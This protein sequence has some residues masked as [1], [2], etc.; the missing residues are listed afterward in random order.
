MTTMDPAWTRLAASFEGELLFDELSRAVYATDASLY[1]EWPLAVAYPKNASDIQLLVR[2]AAQNKL[3]LIPRAGGTSLAGQCV[4]NGIVVDV[5]R[6][7]NQILEFDPEEKWVRVQPGVVRDELNRFLKPHGLFFGP[8]TS[9]TNRCTIGGMAGNNSCG[10]TSIR[11][12][13]TRDHALEIEAVLS[14]GSMARFGEG[15]PLDNPFAQSL[16]RQMQEILLAEP[17]LRDHFP[18]ASIHRRNT[19]YAFDVFLDKPST[20]CPLLCGSEGTLCFFTEIKIHLEPL[21]PP[22]EVLV[23]AHFASVDEALRAV[24]LAMQHPLYACEMMDKTILDCTKE[25]REQRKNRF[26]LEGD[27][28]AVLILE[29]RGNSP[30]EAGELADRL[31]ESLRAES[32]AYAFPKVRPPQSAAVWALRQAGL[33]VL[34]H[35]PNQKKALACI[36]DTAVALEDLPAYI[37]EFRSLMHERFGQESVY[38][39]HA[40]AGELHL[41][42]MLNLRDPHDYAQFRDICEASAQLVKKYRG[43]LSGEHGDGRVRSEF[44]PLIL[45]EE[46]YQLIRKVKSLWDPKNIFN[47]GKIADPLPIRSNLRYSPDQPL[48][49]IDTLLDFSETDGIMGAIEKCNGSGD[50]RKLAQ[51]G[52]TMCPSYMASRQEI[53]STRARANALREFIGLDGS[54]DHPEIHQVLDRC[55]S[56]KG[57]SS[58]CP[59]NVDMA[60]LKAE[61]MHQYQKIHGVPLKNRLFG[62]IDQLYRLAALW[63]GASNAAMRIPGL[64]NLLGLAPRRSLPP[65]RPWRARQQTPATNGK[66]VYLFVDEFTRYLDGDIGMQ[67]V[68]L[69][70]RLGYEVRTPNHPASGRACFSKGL[71]DRARLLADRNVERFAPLIGPDTPL[72]GIEPSAILSF[73]DEYPKIVSPHLREDA[74]RLAPHALTIEEFLSREFQ[75]GNIDRNLFH[76]E[77]RQVILHGHCHQKA[78]SSLEESIWA[79]SIPE[80][81]TVRPLPTGCCGMAGSFGYEKAHYELSMQIGE[82]VLF[83]ALRDAAP[84]TLI[85]AP[86]TSCRHQIW[87]GTGRQALHPIS[88]LFQA[89][90]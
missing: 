76:Q 35:L 46:V 31:I 7:F 72:L 13:T 14:D 19:G 29:L 62:N 61:F 6:H 3:S 36:E 88:I 28:G 20:L 9:T 68:H 39:A 38:F 33:G 44:I 53:D 80:N 86:G 79:L 18:K 51:S 43:S 34:A 42:P 45:G 78:L 52:G 1:R 70:T 10:S 17:G 64:K 77:A 83:P 25:N 12:G 67:A 73:R 21:P 55:L 71:L 65:L 75:A 40:G 60:A 8:N 87:D 69:L 56:C 84:E 74:K 66:A 23:C 37:S 57:C 85:A 50:C 5:S 48:L 11:Y 58:E 41:R 2:F 30:E 49:Q 26:F 59:S 89:L 63:P 54:F 90:K 81:Y 15:L 82:L 22:E 24:L 27:P 47:P 16:H 4:G 32:A